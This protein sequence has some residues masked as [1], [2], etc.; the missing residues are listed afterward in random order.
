MPGVQC[1]SAGCAPHTKYDP[2]QSPTATLVPGKQLNMRYGDGSMST[3]VVYT[4]NVSGKLSRFK[5]PSKENSKRGQQS[6]A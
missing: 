4:D 2:S 3:G 6:A 1:Q 5:V